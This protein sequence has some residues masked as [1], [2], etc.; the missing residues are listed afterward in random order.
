MNFLSIYKSNAQLLFLRTH[1]ITMS[2]SESVYLLRNFTEKRFGQ[3]FSD[4]NLRLYSNTIKLER[5]QEQY[6]SDWFFRKR[7]YQIQTAFLVIL[8]LI[9]FILVFGFFRNREDWRKSCVKKQSIYCLS[10]ITVLLCLSK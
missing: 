9:N 1:K 8:L 3:S 10:R 5:L 4:S 7:L 6:S 2:L